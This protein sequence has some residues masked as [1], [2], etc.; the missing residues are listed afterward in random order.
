VF[1][2]VIEG[3]DVVDKIANTPTDPKDKPQK[4]VV[5]KNIKVLK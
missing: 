5:I 2:Q 4:D 1:G 3:L